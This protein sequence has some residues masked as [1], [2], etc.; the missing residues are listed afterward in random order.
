MVDRAQ[1]DALTICEIFASIQGESTFAGLPCVM[2]RT[3][4]CNLR[5]T[6]C[7]TKYAFDGGTELS[8][9]EIL[10]RVDSYGLALVEITGGEPLMQP[11]AFPLMCRLC[12]RGYTVLLET[13]GSLDITGVDQRV[14]RI[15]DIKTPSSG[16]GD[17][18]LWSNLEVLRL[19]DEIKFVLADR[20][21]Y[22]FAVD[23]MRKH[24][25]AKR[26]KVLMGVVF[27]TLEPATLAEWI[28][29]DRLP[30]RMQIQLHKVIWEP[31]AR[32]V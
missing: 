31:S 7:D 1:P 26:S 17:A 6:Y 5:C 14:V 32:G 30:V 20:R 25:L 19:Q 8:I 27:G 21:D 23:V 2:V 24:E 13:N 18:D 4:G 16:A 3:T 11:A 9:D 29:A 10:T 12:D 22:E 28:L 15:V